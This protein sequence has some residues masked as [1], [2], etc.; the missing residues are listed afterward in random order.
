MRKVLFVLLLVLFG[1]TG[2]KQEPSFCFIQIADPQMGMYEQEDAFPASARLLEQAVEAINEV[3]PAF[4]V[5]TGDMTHNPE[6]EYQVQE[7]QRIMSAIDPSIPVYNL[8]GNHE[9]AAGHPVSQE[10]LETFRRRYGENRFSFTYQGCGF[11]GYD[12]NMIKDATPEQ[13]EA[14]A[15]W[16]EQVLKEYS[17]TCSQIFLFTHCPIVE[18]SKF[19]AVSYFSYQEPYRQKYIDLL[20]RYHVS[21]L[22]CGH[23]HK[24]STF[25]VGSFLQITAGAA[26]SAPLDGSSSGIE[27]VKVYKNHF[28]FNFLPAQKVAEFVRSLK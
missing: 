18:D 23:R 22:F 8:P 5:S 19:E 6:S 17:T 25:Q 2:C 3:H 9:E 4:V 13:E 28:V 10:S 20:E 27:V 26:G 21:A 14:Q 12:S 16:L 7:Y 1:L 24:P 11:I 15:E